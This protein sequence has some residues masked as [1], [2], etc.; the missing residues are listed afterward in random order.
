MG[1]R[2][3]SKTDGGK[4]MEVSLLIDILDAWIA[5]SVDTIAWPRPTPPMLNTTLR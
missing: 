3:G 2:V 4:T 1:D 5:S